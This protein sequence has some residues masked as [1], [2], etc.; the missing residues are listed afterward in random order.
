MFFKINLEEGKLNELS[1]FG[2]LLR[3][4]NLLSTRLIESNS[5]NK[6]AINIPTEVT[7]IIRFLYI[8]SRVNAVNFF[9]NL[10]ICHLSNSEFQSNL[11]TKKLKWR[12]LKI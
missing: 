8:I 12:N 4:S 10:I 6:I 5:E 7:K 9:V 3:S 11:D 1:G 2:N